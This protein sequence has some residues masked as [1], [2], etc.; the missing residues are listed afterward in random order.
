MNLTIITVTSKEDYNS[1]KDAKTE[2]I[3]FVPPKQVFTQDYFNQLLEVFTDRPRF[4]KL[5]M[6]SPSID[7]NG[8]SPIFGWLVS[9]TSILPS[10][11]KSSSE[12]YAAQIGFLPGAVIKKTALERLQQ[13]FTG[14]DLLDSINTSVGLWNAGHRVYVHPKV[15]ITTDQKGMP[16]AYQPEVEEKVK[17]IWKR[18]MVG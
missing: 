15:F 6:V 4:R 18:E 9:P 10:R 12:P 8:N 7:M 2:F 17:Q 13:E 14:A 16:V 5:S 1:W 11:I 3:A